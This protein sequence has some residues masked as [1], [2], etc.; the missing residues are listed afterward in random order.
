[1]LY[2]IWNLLPEII[3]NLIKFMLTKGKIK[4]GIL[5][6]FSL[7]Q[8][9]NKDISLGK[10][11]RIR[12]GCTFSGK[13]N[14]GNYSYIEGNCSLN[15]SYKNPINIGSFCSI[16]NG[17]SILAFNDHNYNK[18][19]SYTPEYG[20]IF[21]SKTEDI[22]KGIFIGNDVWIGKNVIILPGVNVGNGAVIGAGSIVTK[23]V[24]DYAIVGGN[25]AKIIKYRFSDEIIK[26][27]INS[28]WWDWEIN[29]IRKNYNLEFLN[30]K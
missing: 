6:N 12:Q 22:G 11:I 10:G 1:M 25:P 20:N 27:L 29:K 14:I 13:I 28:K 9:I 15:G 21:I 30:N 5:S 3:K 2:K 19:T 17:V 8:L 16:A 26:K 4:F 7:N 24:P 18:L 23:N